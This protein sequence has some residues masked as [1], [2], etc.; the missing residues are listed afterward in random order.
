MKFNRAARLVGVAV[1]VLVANVAASVLYM[2]GRTRV[3]L[4]P[5]AAERER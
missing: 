1:L 3:V 4:A 2:V 5:A